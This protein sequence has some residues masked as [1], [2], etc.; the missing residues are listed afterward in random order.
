MRRRVLTCVV[1]AVL[2][3]S[4]AGCDADGGESRG[5]CAEADPAVVEQ[6]KTGA[7]SDFR[8]VLPDGTP[9]VQIDHLEVL[10]SSVGQLPLKDRKFGAEQLLALLISTVLGEED[11]SEGMSGFEGTILFALDADGKLL[12][13][14]GEFTASLFD[15]ESPPAPGWLEWGD[16]VETLTLAGELYG[17]VDPD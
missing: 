7:R 1:A 14:A 11:A 16:E 9:G 5:A 12:G 10:E 15:L 3:A 17:C 13:P 4:G 8:P 2:L 6:I